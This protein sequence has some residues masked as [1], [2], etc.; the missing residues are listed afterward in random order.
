MYDV[1]DVSRYIINYS[2]EKDYSI[3]NLKL[4][5]LLYFVQAY[6]LMMT[7]EPCFEEKIEAWNFG[8]VVPKAYQE[9]KEYGS[10]EIPEIKSYM[11]VNRKTVD[12]ETKIHITREKFDKKCIKESD[13]KYIEDVV[14]KFAD[15]SALD[16]VRIT[17]NQD[18][19]KEAYSAYQNN[20]ITIENIRRYFDE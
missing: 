10:G 20:E 1:L 11:V 7:G 3:S 9:F 13:G 6:F 8:P 4:Q 12:G 16:L 18:P 15:Y 17:H 14:D 2:N 5:K 19:W